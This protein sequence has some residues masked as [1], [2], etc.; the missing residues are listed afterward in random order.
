MEKFERFFHAKSVMELATYFQLKNEFISW[1]EL[2]V[3][4]PPKA[5]KLGQI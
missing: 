5:S 4:S 1:G 2:T 3:V